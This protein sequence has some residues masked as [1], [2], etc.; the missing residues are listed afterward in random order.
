[1]RSKASR[2]IGLFRSLVV[3][4]G[5]ATFRFPAAALAIVAIA[6]IANWA[7]ANE[8]D[9]TI[10]LGRWILGLVAGAAA[11]VAATLFAESRGSSLAVARL[12]GCA[13][14]AAVGVAVG[15]AHPFLLN[16][17]ALTLAVLTAVPLAPFLGRGSSRSFWDFTLWI[18]LGI[19]LGWFSVVVFL[20]GFTAIF[21][22][23]RTLFGV[24]LTERAY[25]HLF[26]TG[27]TLVGP[28]FA[29]GRVPQPD[30]VALQ[31]RTGERLERAVRPLFEWVTAPLVLVASMII[32][33][34]AAKIIL[35]GD[36]PTNEIGWIVLLYSAFVLSLRLG[37]EPYLNTLAA[38]ARL[39]ARVW[40]AAVV[41]P[42]FLFAYALFLRVSGEGWTIER[43][44]SAAYG[45]A[46]G[47]AVV[48][49]IVPRTRSDIRTMVAVLPVLLTLATFG[50]WGVVA[51]VA[52]SQS[53]LIERDFGTRLRGGADAIQT[54]D[55]QERDVLLSRLDALDD[56][57]EGRH[58][59]EAS[60]VLPEVEPDKR[61][62]EIR[63]LPSVAAI[64]EADASRSID[65]SFE[66]DDVWDVGG[67]D[68]VLPVSATGVDASGDGS[69]LRL[70]GTRLV[71]TYRDQTDR[72]DLTSELPASRVRSAEGQLPALVV[73]LRSAEGRTIRLRVVHLRWSP[74]GEL[75]WLQTAVALRH[76]E[77]ASLR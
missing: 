75:V 50:P 7:I 71:L 35:T 19:T 32:H 1:M 31:D 53:A 16:G 2:L 67:F 14:L 30:A 54:L 9:A 76:G 8:V 27:L 42:L 40:A 61:L 73:D 45:L 29:L 69:S 62:A 33:V 74:Q 36:V 66:T 24:G 28:L 68:R 58:F 57:D 4:S 65:Q 49:Q 13:G 23:V 77:W 72:F 15:F 70:E 37:L 26:T 59:A 55:G 38:P 12:A 18:A 34:Y 25:T 60:G 46:A 63:N 6:A 17:P 11:S 56:V 52:R 21:E 44:F 47:L 10:P 41:V 39:F 22:M 5:R 48:L 20:L 3:R 64:R 43:Y 51:T